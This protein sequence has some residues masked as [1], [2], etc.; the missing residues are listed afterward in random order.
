MFFFMM[1]GAGVLRLLAHQIADDAAGST[2][3]AHFFSSAVA[4]G[5]DK[6]L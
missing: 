4:V 5:E 2:D 3:I 6:V 1:V